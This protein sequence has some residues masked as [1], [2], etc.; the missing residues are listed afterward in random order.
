MTSRDSIASIHVDD[1]NFTHDSPLPYP[2]EVTHAA[3]PDISPQPLP[4]IA[5]VPLPLA[6]PPPSCSVPF[7]PS[8]LIDDLIRPPS[9]CITFIACSNNP[10]DANRVTRN[11]STVTHLVASPRI[12]GLC[13]D[14]V[15]YVKVRMVNDKPSRFIDGGS[16]VCVAGDLYHMVKVIDIEPIPISVALEGAL[17]LL[18]TISPSRASC[19]S[20][21]RMAPHIINHASITQEWSKPSFLLLLSWM[22]AINSSTGLK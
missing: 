1:L 4:Y 9:S 21:L 7:P 20:L 8:S 15:F 5:P 16:N 6:Q 18:T 13:G 17:L 11:H 14:G 10:H 2:M 12:C 3:F 22:Q 19:H